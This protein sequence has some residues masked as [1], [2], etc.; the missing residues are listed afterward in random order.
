MIKAGLE[1][2]MEEERTGRFTHK[3][4]G[5]ATVQ[6]MVK[7]VNER[8]YHVANEG[9]HRGLSEARKKSYLN[10]DEDLRV[11]NDILLVHVAVHG[12]A[13]FYRMENLKAY[14]RKR[15]D[16]A[17]QSGWHEDGFLRVV[18]EV[19]RTTADRPYGVDL[20]DMLCEYALKWRTKLLMFSN[21]LKNDP[22]L[23]E[24][25]A[26]M[27]ARTVNLAT[28]EKND[29][30][31]MLRLR[32]EFYNKVMK[33]KSDLAEN[34]GGEKRAIEALNKVIPTL[35]G[36]CPNITRGLEFPANLGFARDKWWKIHCWS[37][38]CRVEE[39]PA[40]DGDNEHPYTVEPSPV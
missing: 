4:F 1:S 21:D 30:T 2:G 27:F 29:C 15:F 18:R 10:S 6:R 40:V 9:G 39:T 19:Y 26:M 14:A 37:D 33:E 16:D 35:P 28:K 24:F 3:D 13:R 34:L 22:S 5:A 23:Q 12:I 32:T 25:A 17:G 31:Q 11:I 36:T 38:V 8:K 20:R 7:W